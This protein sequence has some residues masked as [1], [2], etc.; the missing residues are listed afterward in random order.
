MKIEITADVVRVLE[1]QTFASGSTKVEVHL[2]WMEQNKDGD[3]YEQVVAVE[4][5]GSR[6][7]TALTL[8]KGDKVKAECYLGGREWRRDENEKWRAFMS[9][10]CARIEKIGTADVNASGEV[11]L[12]SQIVTKAKQQN[13]QADDLPF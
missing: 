1:P 8:N 6:V 5:W 2:T 10:R 13:T 4:C 11:S 9:L 12:K 7:D 3:T